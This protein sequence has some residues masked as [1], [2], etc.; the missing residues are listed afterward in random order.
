MK[1]RLTLCS[2]VVLPILFLMQASDRAQ[3][4]ID[5]A[6][7]ARANRA[8]KPGSAKT[9]SEWFKST[10]AS[11]SMQDK[12][13]ALT[14]FY[15]FGVNQDLRITMVATEKGKQQ[16]TEIMLIN[17][18]CQWMLAKGMALEKGYEID[19]L[20]VPVLNLKFAM[21]L[22][23]AAAPGGPGD[24][25][26]KTTFD[27]HEN[28]RSIAVNT[29][30][31]D[32]GL[33]APWTLQAVIEPTAADQWSFDLSA[34]HG[35]TIHFSGTWQKEATPP[36][37]GDDISL[38]GWQVFILGPM[39][40]AEENATIYDYGAEAIKQHP[41]TIGELRKLTNNRGQ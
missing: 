4:Q 32:G 30:S 21:E 25:K 20:D 19:A 1:L 33:E 16:T 13:V 22:L 39:K 3:A 31:A 8:A 38:D 29:A 41:K 6:A 7:A 23:R 9:D 24:I 2:S 40:R 12:G 27:I 14:T 35:E 37:F 36:P 26:K 28:T 34:S 17:G 5:V 10:R 11:L 15:E 18:K